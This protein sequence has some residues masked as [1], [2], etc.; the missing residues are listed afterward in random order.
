MPARNLQ[1]TQALPDEPTP[2][3]TRT[4][5]DVKWLLNERAALAGT[6]AKAADKQQ[7]L[8]AKRGRLEAQLEGVLQLLARS[9]TAQSRAQA[10]IDAIDVTLGLAHPRVRPTCAGE[11]SAWAGKYG[12]RGG[13]GDFVEQALQ[14]AAPAALT[15]TVLINLA[16]MQFGVAFPLPKDRRAFRKSVSSALTSLLKRGLI[17]PLHSREE[18]SHG[19]WRWKVQAATLGGLRA[20]SEG[21]VRQMEA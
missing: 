5:P 9:R 11:V 12:K 16:S 18:G 6:V 13:L 3:R 8:A 21:L 19:L 14:S 15:T 4:P 7:A 1:T 17:E 10:S 2:A 20:R